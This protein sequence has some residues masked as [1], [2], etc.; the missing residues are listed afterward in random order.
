MKIE[1]FF[2]IVE[3]QW[4]FVFVMQTKDNKTYYSKHSLKDDHDKIHTVNCLTGWFQSILRE[5]E[6]HR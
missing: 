6:E 2:N 4:E 3:K 5:I 1:S